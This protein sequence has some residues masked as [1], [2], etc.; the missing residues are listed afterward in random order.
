MT[1]DYLTSGPSW[2]PFSR[3]PKALQ[4][5]ID[6]VEELPIDP[7]LKSA[8]VSKLENAKKSLD[9]GNETPALNQLSA[10]INQV[11]AQRGKKLS[12]EQADYIVAAA[13]ALIE[14]V[15]FQMGS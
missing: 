3:Q 5:L 8:L 9:K 1:G 10:F 2:S 13:Q 15:N 6:E 4:S 12:N 14:S 11:E 7:G